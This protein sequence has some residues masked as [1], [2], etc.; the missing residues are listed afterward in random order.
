MLSGVESSAI[1]T[2]PRDL[3]HVPVEDVEQAGGERPLD[4]SVVG[5][6]LVPARVPPGGEARPGEQRRYLDRRAAGAAAFEVGVLGRREGDVRRRRRRRVGSH[7]QRV[8]VTLVGVDPD[9]APLEPE[10]A[11]GPAETDVQAGVRDRRR[12]AGKRSAQSVPLG[13]RRR[14]Q[15][16]EGV[17]DAGIADDEGRAQHR[18]VG[19]HAHARRSVALDHYL[20]DLGVAQQLAATVRMTGAMVCAIRAAP[21]T[22]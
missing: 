7:R 17:H 4:G 21:P 5:A 3:R 2:A 1:S 19:G 14:H 15:P 13:Q 22:G 6:P 12:Q 20:G 8:L 16:S 10:L 11:G 18:A 9:V